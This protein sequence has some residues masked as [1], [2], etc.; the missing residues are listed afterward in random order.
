MPPEKSQDASGPIVINSTAD[1]LAP[2]CEGQ[3][4]VQIDQLR[5]G[6]MVEVQINGAV[7]VFLS[8][9]TPLRK[10][11]HTA[12]RCRNTVMARQNTC[13]AARLTG[14]CGRL[15]R[16]RLALQSRQNRCRPRPPTERLAWQS[17]HAF[18]DRS[19]VNLQRG[20]IV[21]R[22]GCPRCPLLGRRAGNFGLVT[23]H[24]WMLT[25]ALTTHTQHFWRVKAHQAPS[26][27][28]WSTTFSF[29]TVAGRNADQNRAG[30]A[31]TTT[32]SCATAASSRIVVRFLSERIISV[33]GTYNDA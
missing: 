13:T 26:A 29:T 11:R 1:C 32:T 10:S 3:T 9:S 23:S 18:L 24:S 5:P 19:R 20:D 31:S 30:V 6:A 16:C 21:R 22:A 12:A 2:L 17:S 7:L 33:S 14:A 27:D 25:T 28:A 4:F 8:S 15:R